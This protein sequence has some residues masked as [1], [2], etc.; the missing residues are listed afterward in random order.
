MSEKMYTL[1]MTILFS[2]LWTVSLLGQSDHTAKFWQDVTEKSFANK[3][4]ERQIIPQAYRTTRINWEVMAP[5]L[6]AAPMRFSVAAETQEVLITLPMPDGS[7]EKFKIVEAPVL[8]KDL[9]KRYPGINAYAGQGIDD[10]TA[11]L[12]FDVTP[13]GFHAMVLSG[14]HSSVFIDPYAKGDTDH[15]ISYYKKD[16]YKES[17][18]TCHVPDAVTDNDFQEIE[19][20][21]PNRNLL[22]GDC[23]LRTYR[24]ALACTGEYAQFH[25]GTTAA[26]LAAMNT[27]MTRVNGV[28]EREATITMVIIPNNDEII[29]LNGGSDPYDNGNGG[30][31]LG[32]NQNTIDNTIGS[33]NYDIGHVYSTGGGGIAS[34]RSPCSGNRKAQGVT[35][36]GNP[37]GDPFDI[38]YVAHE[39]GH[40][41]GGNHTQNNNCNNVGGISVEPGSASTIMGYAGICSPNVQNNSDDYFHIINLREIASNVTGGTSSDCAELTDTGNNAPTAEAGANYTIPVS[42]PFALTGIATDADG[43]ESLTYNWEQ[44]DAEQGQPMPPNPTNTQGPVFRSISP[45]DSPTRYFPNLQA[46]IN[47]T[48]PTWEVLPSVARMM[49]FTFSVRDNHMGGGCVADDDMIV[50]VSPAAGPFLVQNPNTNVTWYV[51]DNQTVEWDVAN[52]NTAPVNCSEVNI[53][54]S[55]DG[56]LTYDII[57]AEN[58]PNNGAANI[59]VPNNIGDDNRV[60]VFCANNVFYDISN[61]DFEIAEPLEPTFTMNA[62]PASQ[63]VCAEDDAVYEFNLNSL[64]GFDETTT[65]TTENLPAGVTATFSVTELNPSGETTLTISDLSAG[66][67]G[68]YTIT[69][70]ADAA[71]VQQSVDISLQILGGAPAATTLMSPSS[72]TSGTSQFPSLVWTDLEEAS[73][74]TIEISTS[75]NFE[76]TIV[77]T[78]VSNN[79]YSPTDLMG[80]TVYYWRVRAENICGDADFSDM[81]SFQTGVA[82]CTTFESGDVPIDISTTAGTISSTLNIPDN[83]TI[84]DLNV[85]NLDIEH[86]WVGDILA[87]LMHPDETTITLMDQPGL[88]DINANFGCGGDNLLVS[89]DDDAAATAEDLEAICEDL[90]AIEGD[91]QPVE[92]LSTFAGLNAQGDWVLTLVDNADEDGGQLKNWSLE[93]C[94]EVPI[95]TTPTVSQ[96]ILNVPQGGM[97][98]VSTAFLEVTSEGSSAADIV[99]IVT[100]LPNNGSLMLNGQALSVGSTFTQ[101]DIDNGAL[102]YVQNGTVANTD[103]FQYDVL[104]ANDG[105]EA[106]NTFNINILIDDLAATATLGND[107]SCNAANDGSLSVEVSGGTTPYSYSLDGENFQAENL[108]T[109]LAAG[110][111]MATVMDA[112]GL[113]LTSNEVTI[114]EPSALELNTSVDVDEVMATASGGTT[115]YTYS[116]DG[117]NFQIEP[118]FSDLEN[119]TYTITVQDAN[120]CIATSNAIVA[121]DAVIASAT[122]IQDITCNNANDGSLIVEIGGGTEPFQYSLDGENFQTEAVF[123]GLS[124]GTYSVV[125]ID[126]NEQMTMTN[127]IVITN[128]SAITGMTTVEEATVTVTASGG[129]G[130]LTYSINGEIFQDIN[131]FSELENDIYNIIIMDENGCTI[132]VSATVSVNTLSIVGSVVEEILCAGEATGSI[133]AAVAGGT[134]PF[135]YS[136]DGENFQDD[137]TFRD[138]PAGAYTITVMDSGGFT[139]TTE[140][141]VLE[142]PAI[143]EASSTVVGTSI[144]V[145]ATGGTGTLAY[146]IDGQTFQTENVFDNLTNDTYDIVVMDENGCTVILSAMVNIIVSI[147]PET[148]AISCNG[149][150]DGSITVA[151]VEGGTPPYQYSLNDGDFQ[152]NNTFAD[153]DAASY[154][155][156]VQDANGNEFNL[157]FSLENPALLEVNTTVM[158]DNITI[159]ASGGTGDLQYSIDGGVTF[160]SESVFANLENGVYDIVVMDA[161]ACQSTDSATVDVSGLDDL[162]IDLFFE[163][164]PNPNQGLFTMILNQPTQ[165]DLTIQIVDALGRIVFEQQVIKTSLVFQQAMEL[166]HLSD[167][168]YFLKVTD[169]VLL[170]TQQVLI[171]R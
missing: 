151:T 72:G 86:S 171:I 109:G 162:K 28:Y 75:P 33:A 83:I 101:A 79:S 90:P 111:Y 156:T 84:T 152:D 114:S 155:L 81:F 39:M 27:S 20:D 85:K 133:N 7:T 60:Q 22:V 160:G 12:R 24:L 147:S 9:A 166:N 141:I 168:I 14:K 2:C 41:Y 59:T 137:D 1:S 42:T 161:N 129:T 57:L 88:P 52:T 4:A 93:V 112:N 53:L 49:N 143:L 3:N 29:F 119:G 5:A 36:Q 64:A 164:Q 136:L 122:L 55:T 21:T 87:T 54:L 102:T 128:P 61:T 68:T 110:A 43:L 96:D 34:L 123:T 13:K 65:F 71:S 125:V 115:D 159:E 8:H 140:A 126:D 135:Q 67:A 73:A 47:N 95:M 124:A 148:T 89:F 51:G 76:N 100:A 23:Q 97:S 163:V 19:E 130:D 132:T 74:Y 165:K 46:V 107:V 70:H 11:Y 62:E 91:F 58:V 150:S 105:W 26:T 32:Q 10:P 98:T 113:S 170:G 56:G 69:V 139:Q 99:F 92:S 116:I 48:T 103:T 153:L 18:F 118:L 120:G 167:G 146:S 149:A 63:S 117:E 17:N 144:N 45:T 37:V 104:D 157:V 127:E 108:F 106:N 44:M 31:M 82:S 77:S 78:T 16:F 6:A 80:A 15:Y 66:I 35:G 154:T 30:A 142:A 50:N 138:L 131:V 38:D 145:M 158:D 121:V 169:G 25:G 40:Q 134:E 94:F